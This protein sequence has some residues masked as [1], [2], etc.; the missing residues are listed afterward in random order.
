MNLL[1][2]VGSWQRWVW[3]SVKMF[4]PIVA[5]ALFLLGVVSLLLSITLPYE[6][7]WST[8]AEAPIT[9]FN[10][11]SALSYESGI[12]PNAAVLLQFILLYLFAITAHAFLSALYLLYNHMGFISTVYFSIYLYML[13]TFRFFQSDPR[14]IL[15]NYMTFPS[16]YGTYGAIFPAFIVLLGFLALSVYILPLWKKRR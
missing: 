10:Q 1:A 14:W 4:S 3:Y 6:P 11:M 13:V 7:G 12:T 8:F 16:S 15:Y 5:V 2:R 9:T